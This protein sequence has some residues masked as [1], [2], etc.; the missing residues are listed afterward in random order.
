MFAVV[1]VPVLQ[2]VMTGVTTIY[3]MIHGKLGRTYFYNTG[4]LANHRDCT[5]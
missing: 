5:F 4:T 1:D 3:C 2:G